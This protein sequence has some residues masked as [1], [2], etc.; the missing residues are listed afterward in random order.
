MYASDFACSERGT[1]RTQVCLS[2]LFIATFISALDGSSVITV[3]PTIKSIGNLNAL[4]ITKVCK[5]YEKDATTRGKSVI[6][7]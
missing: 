5:Y 4:Y 7:H 3:N 1:N 6:Y 2:H